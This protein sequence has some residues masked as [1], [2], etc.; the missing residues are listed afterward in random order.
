MGG[1]MVADM[2]ALTLAD[3]KWRKKGL[4]GPANSA[5]ASSLRSAV[6]SG[7]FGVQRVQGCTATSVW[8]WSQLN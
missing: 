4:M 2:K 8:K 3:W 5:S 7:T 6:S 1:A